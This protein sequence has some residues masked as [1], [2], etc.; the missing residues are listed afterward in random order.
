[1][2]IEKIEK[3]IRIIIKENEDKYLY[4]HFIKIDDIKDH[5]ELTEEIYRSLIS[6]DDDMLWG[7]E[8]MC[9]YKQGKEDHSIDELKK[10]LDEILD[11]INIYISRL[12][13]LIPY[14]YRNSIPEGEVILYVP[15]DGIIDYL[16]IM[17]DR[18]KYIR[19]LIK[20]KENYIENN[21]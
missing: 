8:Q 6:Q 19:Q 15:E 11:D 5:L 17:N 20:I 21:R 14:P 9:L 2:N 13:K 1:M 16:E 18:M 4:K 12:A 3:E 10:E 7:M